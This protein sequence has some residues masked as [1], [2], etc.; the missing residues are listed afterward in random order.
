MYNYENETPEKQLEKDRQE[1]I[2]TDNYWRN[3]SKSFN[4]PSPEYSEE[5][6]PIKEILRNLIQ[7]GGGRFFGSKAS[8]NGEQEAWDAIDELLLECITPEGWEIPLTE[9]DQ[10]DLTMHGNEQIDIDLVLFRS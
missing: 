1:G 5:G 6:T 4:L 2:K 7:K 10:L 9:R 8:I 3:M